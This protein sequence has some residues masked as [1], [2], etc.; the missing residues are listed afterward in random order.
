MRKLNYFLSITLLFFISSIASSIKAQTVSTTDSLALV[1]LYNATDGDNWTRND[2]WLVGPVNTWYGVY[3]WSPSGGINSIWLDNNNL[4]GTIPSEIG[5]FGD[6]RHLSLGDNNL[7]GPIP[8]EIGNITGL[9]SLDLSYNNLTGSIPVE[10]GNLPLWQSVELQHNQLTGNIPPSIGYSGSVVEINLSF[11]KLVGE[12]PESFK[13]KDIQGLNLSNNQ[14]EG[15]ISSELIENPAWSY[16]NFSNNQFVGEVKITTSGNTHGKQ[17]R[18]NDNRLEKVTFQ[19]ADAKI[20]VLNISN[21][22]IEDL[23]S[24]RDFSSIR[25]LYTK[26]NRITFEDIL[27]LISKPNLNTFEYDLQ[28]FIGQDTTIYKTEG[29]SFTTNLNIDKNISDNQYIWFKDGIAIDTTNANQFTLPIVTLT[30]AGVYTCQVTNPGAPDLTLESK[31]YTLEVEGDPI[32][33]RTVVIQDSLALVALYNATD[34]DNWT[35]KDNWLVGP[36]DTWYGVNIWQGVWQRRIRGIWL[37]ENNLKGSLPNEIGDLSQIYFLSLGNNHLSGTLPTAMGNLANLRE[38]NVM[39]NEF[40]GDIPEEITN[41]P[42]LDSADFG[43]NHFT[44]IGDGLKDAIY[45]TLVL[46]DNNFTCEDILPYMN[47]PHGYIEYTPQAQIGH[48]TTI[49]LAEGNNFTIDLGIDEN[50]SDNEYVWFKDGIAIDTTNANQ[51]TLPIVTLTDAGIYTCKVTNPGAPDLTLQ[52]KSYT[53]EVEGDPIENRTVIIQD[54]LALVA[55]YNATDGD[56]WTRNDNWLSGSVNT[57]YGVSVSSTINRVNGI[58]LTNNN[59]TGKLPRKLNE[60]TAITYFGIWNNNVEDLDDSLFIYSNSSSGHLLG[61]KFTFEDLLN[62]PKLKSTF[63]YYVQQHIGKDTT[64]MLKE[65]GTYTIDLMIDQNVPNNKYKWFKNN[66]PINTTNV[67][68]F[69]ISAI[70]FSDAGAYTCEVTNPDI[71]S[72]TLFSKKVILALEKIE[73]YITFDS[74]ANKTFEDT[75]INLTASA[76]SGLPINFSID[77]GLDSIVTFFNDTTLQIVG[78]GEVTIKA[79]QDGNEKYLPAPPVF[80]SFMV[81]KADQAISFDSVENK[82]YGDAP[83]ELMASSSSNLPVSYH[84]AAGEN[85]VV[86]WKNDSTLEIVGSGIVE[87]QA[88][89]PGNKNYN[90]ASPVSRTFTV[91]K[92]E[93][94]IT[95]D[96]IPDQM[97]GDAAFTLQVTATSG[98]D[99][100]FAVSGPAQL[101]GNVLTVSDTGTVSIT[102]SQ[103]GNENYLPAENVIQTFYVKGKETNVEIVYTLSGSVINAGN[104]A[105]SNG[106]VILFRQD[107]VMK[108]QIYA[109]QPLI[110]NNTFRFE[111][112]AEGNYTL[113]AKAVDTNFLPTYFGH[114]LLLAEA[115][116]ITIQSDMSNQMIA[117]FSK[118]KRSKGN[119]IISGTLLADES[120]AGNR[121]LGTEGTPLSGIS[122]FLVEKETGELIAYDVTDANGTF[123]FAGLAAG[124]YQLLADYDGL[125]VNSM[126]NVIVVNNE[127]DELAVVAKIAN[128]L[129][130]VSIEQTNKITGIENGYAPADQGFKVYPTIV[131]NE[132]TINFTNTA[133]QGGAVIL[134]DLSGKQLEERKIDGENMFFE[135]SNIKAG[136]YLVVIKTN[137]HTAVV[138]IIKR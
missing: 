45:L 41:L 46:E 31:S 133:W 111:N 117:V 9:D 66:V 88:L 3:S 127:T 37:G 4:T 73:Q 28:D 104:A 130:I 17:L 125:G 22:L 12:I 118:P 131:E 121:L 52:S 10:M 101:E 50:I 132:L 30:D 77:Q 102:A 126:E 122:V 25:F 95:F 89:Q 16:L 8:V 13:S 1:A 93:Q 48:D 138:K 96:A 44:G 64:V 74:V 92:T 34:G 5:N 116:S 57:W 58:D 65:G 128:K 106:E 62:Q 69:T 7:T 136:F 99:I 29:V 51:F 112:L 107:S 100:S 97:L 60:L 110:N 109:K 53:L 85:E 49:T 113:L 87:I 103:S 19:T 105:M 78:T 43:S 11:N 56:N 108:W 135:M 70:T 124:E 33:N 38:L 98:L 26:G 90:Q 68:H 14:L 114:Q 82:N 137:Q 119:A 2:N 32:E 80:R 75:N 21:N 134:S 35:R 71:P 67:N 47:I 27:T 81:E 15:V 84:I 79:S 23:T 76:T 86:I 54:S 39:N 42:A 20:W 59:L 40:S 115:A 94:E 24:I 61:N 18:L 129:E 55:L 63:K 91:N 120:G 123:E 83:I 6:L 36:V 72:L